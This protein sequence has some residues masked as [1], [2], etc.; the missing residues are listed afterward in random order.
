MKKHF[1]LYKAGKLWLIGAIATLGIMVGGQ[2][3]LADTTIA[4]AQQQSSTTAQ[5][6][7]AAPI[8]QQ[9][10]ATVQVVSAATSQSMAAAQPTQ[11]VSNAALAKAPAKQTGDQGA[12]SA[13]NNNGTEV[14]R[15][16]KWYL[17]DK[18]GQDLNGWQKLNDK[19]TVYYDPSNNAMVHGEKQIN[20]Y[21]Y[22]FAENNGQVS[23]G[24]TN[25]NDGRH[26]YYNEKGQMQHGF[27]PITNKANNTTV[28]YHFAEN[29]GDMTKGEA[30]LNGHW[31][32]FGNDGKMMTGFHH[33][34]GNRT[35]YYSD[36][37]NAKGQMQ[38]GLTKI[39]NNTYYFAL[40]NGDMFRGEHNI[41][42]HWYNFGTNGV[43][44]T[45]FQRIAGNR[46]V[47]Y[48]A[49]GQ[50]QKGLTKVGN[51]AY[52]FA[53]NDGN[54][55]KGEVHAN[56]QWYNFDN[57]G[58]M[59][60]GFANIA[61]NRRV[62]YNA[63]GQMQKGLT[64]VGNNTYYFALNNGN[65]IKGEVQTNGHWYNFDNYGHMVTGFANIAGNRT[66]YYNDN[67]Q[68]LYGDQLIGQN[69]YHFAENNGDMARHG[70]TFD[71]TT[72]TFK[73]FEANGVRRTDPI[74]INKTSY[75]FDPVTGNLKLTK[76]GEANINGIWYY[77]NNNGTLATGFKNIAGN[78]TVYY[79][80]S[81]AQMVHGESYIGG[82]WYFFALNNGDM[83]K[84]FTVLPDGRH[85]YY[86]QN[87]QM[88]YGELNVNGNWYYL[89]TNNGNMTVGFF[90]LPD[91][92]HVYYDPQ[93]RM[94]HGFFN[95]NGV[96]NDYSAHW[97]DNAGVIHSVHY[98][99]Q[100]TP[101]MAPWGCAPTSLAMLMSIKN[102]YPGLG[103][104]IA[105][106]PKEPWT[107]G[108][109]TGNQYSGVGFTHVITAAALTDYAHRWSNDVKNIS[110]TSL[111]GLIREVQAGHPVLYYGY[112]A[113]DA[114]GARNHCK[115][116][117]G[118]NNRTGLFHV[119]DPLYG[120]RG[121]WAAGTTG[122]NRY[123]LGYDAWVTWGSI[124]SEYAGN[125]LTID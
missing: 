94:A 3:A 69:W 6:V 63:N 117:Y 28:T 34:A 25:L 9:S 92:R 27:T 37:E 13:V 68:M 122:R 96:S 119:Y 33:I 80:P 4:P 23:I 116:I 40:N 31:Y 14:T 60:T 74:T 38:K 8:Q 36:K 124:A 83:A 106:L 1:K 44:M 108:G 52:Y 98:F 125:A 75:N 101:I 76:A 41:N 15:N 88:Q 47:Y 32:N 89:A 46:T 26:V 70:L 58:H 99:S 59:V 55:V 87:G 66:V 118:Y 42:N 107:P 49:N 93:G 85:V 51:N 65:M 20:S 61:G 30:Q 17:Q 81:N 53:L 91:G 19:R 62:Y 39:G 114:G 100:Y 90:T 109:Q 24:F 57:Y 22:H 64:K 102:I 113:Y 115:V 110:G 67:G 103:T 120:H 71:P 50:M 84:G 54:M 73:Y 86:N 112:S 111:S 11:P 95:A 123:D 48:D 16:G 18:Q 79:N 35:V 10:S 97:A 82:H 45:G 29:N 77:V 104:L 2:Q 43:M 121:H 7:L 56:G 78:R 21:W 12:L 105:N 5:V 72:K